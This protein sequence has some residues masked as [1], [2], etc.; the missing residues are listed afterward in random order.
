MVNLADG[1]SKGNEDQAFWGL[2][3]MTAAQRNLPNLYA[4]PSFIEFAGSVF[5][6]LASPRWNTSTC[7]RGIQWQFNPANNSFY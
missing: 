4:S 6:D 2:T 3:A 5:K 7:G 1:I